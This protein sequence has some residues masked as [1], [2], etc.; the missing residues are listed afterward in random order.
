MIASP[1][2]IASAMSPRSKRRMKLN[3]FSAPMRPCSFIRT[4]RSSPL[5]RNSERPSVNGML[6]P[7]SIPSSRN[8]LRACATSSRVRPRG[9]DGSSQTGA[10]S[11]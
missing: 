9:G 2:R 11:W 7:T 3:T 10:M 4:P 5:N 1:L 6:L 8:A